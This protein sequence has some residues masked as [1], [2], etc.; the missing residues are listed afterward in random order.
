VSVPQPRLFHASWLVP[1][2]AA[3]LMFLT[4]IK[5]PSDAGFP[6]FPGPMVAMIMSNQTSAAYLSTAYQP[7][8]NSVPAESFE[9]TNDGTLTSS[10]PSISTR[11]GSYNNK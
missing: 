10:M 4:I 2:G 5:P 9:W 3:C 8:A 11:K 6:A 1:A 7:Q